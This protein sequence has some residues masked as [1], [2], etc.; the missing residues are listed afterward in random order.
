VS[1]IANDQIEIGQF[2]LFCTSLI[3]EMEW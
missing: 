1:F 2:V 3:V